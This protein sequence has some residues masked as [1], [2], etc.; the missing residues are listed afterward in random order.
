MRHGSALLTGGRKEKPGLRGQRVLRS[1]EREQMGSRGMRVTEG[2]CSWNRDGASVGQAQ[3][4]VG[5][6]I[7]HLEDKG[8]L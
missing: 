1:E 5:L 7:I 3:A 4:G 6:F 8:K 2:R